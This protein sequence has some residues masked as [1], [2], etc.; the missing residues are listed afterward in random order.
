[1][2]E[3]VKDPGYR[4]TFSEGASLDAIEASLVL[5]VLAT[6]SVFGRSR[7][8]LEGRFA[9]DRRSRT[10]T[11]QAG[12]EVGEHIARVFTGFLSQEIDERAFRVER[13]STSGALDSPR[14]CLDA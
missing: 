5:S 12:T 4:Y 3:P 10:C 13:V 8:R 7:V 1:M 14:R 6:E 9:L 11:V 2:N